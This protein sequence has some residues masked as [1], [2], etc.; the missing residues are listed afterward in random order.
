MG[1]GKTITQGAL[2]LAGPLGWGALAADEVF[3]DG[4]VTSAIG[5][6]L[7]D[8]TGSGSTPSYNAGI[9]G[10][11]FQGTAP[12]YGSDPYARGMNEWAGQHVN[13][14]DYRAGATFNESTRNRGPQAF[15]NSYLSGQQQDV[16]DYDQQG[17]LQLAREAAMGMAP[18]EAA[19]LMQRGLDQSLSTQE[20]LRGGARG[21]AGVALAGSNAANNSANLMQ[22]AFTQAQAGRANEMAQGRTLYGGIAGTMREQDLQRIAQANEQS[23]FNAQLNDQYRMGMGNLSQGYGTQGTNWFNAGAN[24]LNQAGALGANTYGTNA[25]IYGIDQGVAK[26]RTLAQMDADT[27]E[28]NQNKQLAGTVISTVGSVAGGRK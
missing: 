13:D 28:S 15:E 5:G 21:Q 27:Q 23:R 4:G 1:L 9:G 10:T 20:G 3:N 26:D 8:A 11:F 14:A 22:N 6:A 19:F 2:G 17:A 16:R 25:S 18:S 24:A 12:S 7:D